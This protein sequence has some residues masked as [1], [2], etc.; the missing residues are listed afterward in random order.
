MN[1]FIHYYR[2]NLTSGDLINIPSQTD[3][4]GSG[5]VD[6]LS[7]PLPADAQRFYRLGVRLP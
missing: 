1:S 6:T 3:L 2:T 5:G 4:P 7:D